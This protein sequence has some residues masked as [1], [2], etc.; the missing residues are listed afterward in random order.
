MTY[1][2]Y[3][4]K[5]ARLAM[6]KSSDLFHWEKCGLLFPDEQWE[7]FFPRK[8]YRSLFPRGWSKSGAILSSQIDGLYWMF[9]GDTH[10]FIANSKD[11][12][13]WDVLENPVISP[14][15]GSFDS[16]LVEP[17]PPPLLLPEGIWLGYNSANE[18]IRYSFGQCLIDAKNP[19]IVI[20]RSG[21]PILEPSTS[22]E[23]SGQVP[24]VV[25]GEGLVFFKGQWLLYYG[26][27]DSRIG[28]A[29]LERSTNEGS[30]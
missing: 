21:S 5:I 8:E 2:A 26:M 28:V 20:H 6:A 22:S 11:L 14:R 24:Q 17:G 16:R 15:P 9:F 3:D 29:F 7:L 10:I 19:Q 23:V 30:G 18:N 13:K 25:F 1:T 4:G 27:A 12:Q